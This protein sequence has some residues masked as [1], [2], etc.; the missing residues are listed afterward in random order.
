MLAGLGSA[1]DRQVCNCHRVNE[2][3]ICDAIKNGADSVEAI[4]ACTKAGTGCGSC[5]GEL[6]RLIQLQP[7]T[8]RM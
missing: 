1:A 4:G 2:N 6:Q 3:V 7:A 8:A 5:R